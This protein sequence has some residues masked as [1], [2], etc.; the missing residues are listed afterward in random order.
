MRE[1]VERLLR[2]RYHLV[3]VS[4]GEE[5]LR[6]ALAN[7]P[8]LILS[9]VM[10]PV[11]DGF[12]LLRELRDH[13]ETSTIPVVL[14]SAR[15]GE[16][17]RVEGLDAGADDYLIKPFT[18]RELLARVG[19]HLAMSRRRQAAER[20]LQESQATLQ[21][22][23]DSSP[24]MMG[25]VELDGEAILP[26]YSNLATEKFFD[27]PP[28]TFAG[29]GSIQRPADALWAEKYR[30]S[31]LA[32]KP[33]HFEY[34]HP[35][36]SGNVWLSSTV[37]YLGQSA[38]GRPK[39]CYVTEDVTDRKKR[40]ALLRRSNDELR[41]ANSDLEQFAYS[42]SHDLQEP[43][44]QVAIYSQLLAREYS[45]K[46]GEDATQ[47]LNYCIEGAQRMERLVS[48]LL[49]YSQATK[50][51]GSPIQ[52][53][54]MNEALEAAEKNL[55]AT[56]RETGAEITA[57]HLPMVYGDRVPLM[58]VFQNLISNALKYRSA[59]PPRVKVWA[60]P[61]AG[62]WRFAV[63]DNGIGIAKQFHEQIFGIF[64]RLHDRRDYPGTG[65][66]LAICQKVI[67][68]YGGKIWVESELGKGTTFFF[69]LPES[70]VP[71]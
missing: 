46:L 2:Y 45:E 40:E 52:F 43:L 70:P 34:E 19:A 50:G 63:Q 10:M 25:V 41:R 32:G 31:R 59:A 36:P 53:V 16:E 27:V 49:A 65:I 54:D 48:D 57:E 20:A 38:G 12:G 5:A 58:H 35:R 33:V 30:E 4:N 7:P 66:G 26:L 29:T 37:S 68:R 42:A 60:E 17:S 55:T 13:H 67:E 61:D 64:K 51:T 15:A 6:A 47:Y 3:T 18:A 14:V 39:F 8:D 62:Y 56:M 11:L 22:F 1:Y 21:S 23:Y 44:R 69:T 71:L 24:L 28:G 9:D